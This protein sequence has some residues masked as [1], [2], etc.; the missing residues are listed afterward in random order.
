MSLTP[1]HWDTFQHYRDRAPPWIKLHR[2]LLD[3]VDYYRLSAEAGKALPLIWLLASEK[4]G[5]VPDAAEVAFRLRID[6]IKAQAILTELVERRFLVD[7]GDAAPAE[8]GATLAQR[9]AK[10]NGF[11]SRHIPDAVKRAV[12]A[13]DGGKCCQCGS[14]E[15]VEFDHKTPVSK[16]G[17]SDEG[18]IQLLC[19]P[20]NRRKR[21]QDAAPAEQVATQDRGRRS[22]EKEG[23][24]EKEAKTDIRAKGPACASRFDEF[25]KAYPRREG[26]N[27]RKP[28]EQKFNALVKTGVDDEF[29]IAEVKKFAGLDDTRKNIGTRFIPQAVTWLNQQRWADHAAVSAAASLLD[30][31]DAL[32]ECVKMFARTGHWSK[33]APV[34]DIT[35]APADLLAK[36]GLGTDGRKLPPA[37]EAA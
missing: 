23:E 3:N 10:S 34:A 28:A 22:P 36:H 31:K 19:R 18:N 2:G 21:T 35:K 9:V 37:A 15:N 12:W 5:I 33:W 26:P 27:P 30:P 6:E 25:W 14:S 24:T 1:K 4:D 8:H 17:T 29:L 11:G 16:G 7:A 20:C 13:R 32:E